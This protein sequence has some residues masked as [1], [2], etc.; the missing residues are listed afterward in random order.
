[1][2]WQLLDVGATILLIPLGMI[3]VVLVWIAAMVVVISLVISYPI[4]KNRLPR[5]S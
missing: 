3:W 2:F 4:W 5:G 1:M